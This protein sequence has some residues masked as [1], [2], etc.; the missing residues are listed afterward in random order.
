M[1]DII[2]TNGTV[3]DGSGNASFQGDIGIVG[4]KIVAVKPRIDGQADTVIDASGLVVSPGF[5]DMHSHSDLEL[6]RNPKAEIKIRQGVTTEVLGQDGIAVAPMLKPKIKKQWTRQISGLLGELADEWDWDTVGE[7]MGKLDRKVA[8][9][10]TYLVPHGVVRSHVIGMEDRRASLEELA[11]MQRI[12]IQAMD[13]GAVGF[14]TGLVYVPCA[15]GDAI[16]MGKLCVPVAERDGVFMIHI[17]NEGK[18]CSEAINEALTVGEL[19]DVRVHVSHFKV[20]GKASWGRAREFLDNLYKGRNEG[21]EISF[22]QYPYTAGSSMLPVLL[23][24]KP[25]IGLGEEAVRNL[26]NRAIR[27]EI[28][29]KLMNP[30]AYGW[31][32]AVISHG[33]DAIMISSVLSDRNKH[34]EGKMLLEVAELRKEDPYDTIL[35]LLVEEKLG[36]SIVVFAMCEEDVETIMKDPIGTISSDGIYGTNPHPRVYGSF[37]RVLGRY[38]RERKVISLEEAIRKMTSHAAETLRLRA[39]G[40]IKEGYAADLV[41]FDSKKVIDKATY[42][43]PCQYPEGIYHVIVNGESVLKNGQHTGATPGRVLGM[44]L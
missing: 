21:L 26:Q 23:P 35:N 40:L 11:D 10:T 1:F 14:S 41:V 22:D 4:D 15:Y 37:P 7:Y 24:P 42:D 32:N 19:S 12:V 34:L 3:V 16:E 33:I 6:L 44:R 2:I 27:E 28:K 8:V 20:A 5:I 43:E 29:A 17:R 36:V 18:Q 31:N 13:E 30:E 39:R 9:N 38:V 25:V